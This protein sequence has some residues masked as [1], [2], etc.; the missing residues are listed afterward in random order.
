MPARR[1]HAVVC[2]Q[3]GVENERSALRLFEHVYGAVVMLPAAHLEPGVVQAHGTE[4]TGIDRPRALPGGIDER[5]GGDHRRRS[6]VRGFC[7]MARPTSCG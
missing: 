7:S 6:S 4:A 2:L 3:N 1:R 5:C